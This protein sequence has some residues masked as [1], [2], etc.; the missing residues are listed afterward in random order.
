MTNTNETYFDLHISGVGYLNRIRE[1]EPKKGASFWACDIVALNGP[2]NAVEYKR[3]DC[4][5]SG[6]EAQSLVR[7]CQQAVDAGKKVLI[8]FRL[9]DL[10]TD[11]FTHAK[12]KKAGQTG[13]S[14][15]ARLLFIGWIKVDGELVYQAKPKPVETEKVSDSTTETDDTGETLADSA[16]A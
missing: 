16:T 1:V 5:I 11:T 4:R 10:W 13:V 6:S 15:K 2:S 8:S 3:F 9:G 14:L 12:G 7:R